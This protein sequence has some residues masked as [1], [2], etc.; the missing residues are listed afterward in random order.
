MNIEEIERILNE[1]PE[2]ATH[3]DFLSKVT[4]WKLSGREGGLFLLNGKWINGNC[5]HL[6]EI[7]SLSDLRTIL[8]QH[9]RIKELEGQLKQAEVK[10]IEKLIGHFDE[11]GCLNSSYEEGVV[12]KYLSKLKG[13]QDG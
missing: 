13:E 6:P 11:K 7:Q 4:Y 3:Y 8:D 2:G 1:A 10:A 9:N 5:N 12:N